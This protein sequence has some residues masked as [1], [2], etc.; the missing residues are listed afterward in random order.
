MN[1]LT[2]RA[3]CSSAI[4]T[5]HVMRMIA[6][7]QAWQ[8]LGGKVQFVGE[9][10][11]LHRRLKKEGFSTIPVTDVYPAPIDLKT[12]LDV[13]SKGH[14]VVIDGYHFD[15]A[16]QKAVRNA[17]RKTLVVDDICDRRQY[18]AD[19]LLNQNPDA[20]KY[21]YTVNDDSLKLLGSQYALLRSE[22]SRNPFGNKIIPNT[23]QKILVTLGGADPSNMTSRV[24]QAI[25]SM[26]STNLHVKIVAGPANPHAQAI[27]DDIK[28]LRCTCEVLCNAENMPALMNWADLAVSAAGSTCWELSYIGTPYIAIQ[29]A[30]NQQGIINELKSQ[31]LALCLDTDASVRDI[32]SGMI[33]LIPDQILRQT[34]HNKGQSLIDGKGTRRVAQAM[35]SKSIRLRPA[36]HGDS[37]ILL[38]WRNAPEIRSNSFNSKTIEPAEHIKWY[39]QKLKDPSCLFFIAEDNAGNPVGQVRF[40]HY[41]DYAIISIS[42][43]PNMKGKGIGTR[44]TQLG[45]IALHEK[46]PG[47]IVTAQIKHDNPASI[48]MFGKAGFIEKIS[49]E[50]HLEF[51]WFPNDND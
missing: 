31:G 47:T 15:T 12:L 11:P 32:A 43:A 22:F 4:G 37:E 25:Q 2:I 26:D 20:D 9:T 28:T 21:G 35:L 46:W 29:I 36:T 39:K 50:D 16:Y 27:N 44:M 23:A 1:T 48:S 41:E 40:E 45:C 19:I 30:D 33:T 34:M 51:H 42:V 5:G 49:T 10:T 17:G 8:D 6:L 38:T 24:L 3:D 13:T 14:W 7:G 18:N